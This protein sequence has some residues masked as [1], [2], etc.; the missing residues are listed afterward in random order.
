MIPMRKI[1]FH[2]RPGQP[3]HFVHQ[4]GSTATIRLVGVTVSEEFAEWD[5]EVSENAGPLRLIEG[6]HGD[7]MPLHS[8]WADSWVAL[9]SPI[10]FFI[11]YSDPR[12]FFPE[13]VAC[14]PR[15]VQ[16]LIPGGSKT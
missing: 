15:Q 10:R 16:M 4:D 12:R 6:D 3:L 7:E 8:K 1:V 11:D 2:L 14:V 5:V 13:F 9:C